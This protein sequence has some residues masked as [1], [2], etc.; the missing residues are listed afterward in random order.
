MLSLNVV[1]YH[2]TLSGTDDS[3]ISQIQTALVSAISSACSEHRG[4]M[5]GFQ[6][7]RFLA[8]FNAVTNVGN[9]ALQAVY[10]AHTACRAVETMHTPL[11][12]TVGVASGSAI[13]GNMGSATIKRFTI[14]G[15]VVSTAATLER[16]A[17]WYRTDGGV[18]AGGATV[19]DVENFFDVLTV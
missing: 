7:D 11:T 13:V 3:K 5:D 6:G 17:K 2:A 14:L 12:V 19:T 16:L 4:V 1:G 10:A 9:H 15:H 18:L 8:S